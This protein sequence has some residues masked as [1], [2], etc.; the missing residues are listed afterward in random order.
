MGRLPNKIEH[1][2]APCIRPD[3]SGFRFIQ[4]AD[5]VSWAERRADA[6]GLLPILVRKLV[7]ATTPSTTFADFPGDKGI[8]EV[9]EPIAVKIYPEVNIKAF[10]NLSGSVPGCVHIVGVSL[11][12]FSRK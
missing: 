5:I 6:P 12:L 1:F 3:M 7:I 8:P 9:F 11:N 10:I 4:A 2:K